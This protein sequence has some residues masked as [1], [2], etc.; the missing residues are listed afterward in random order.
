LLQDLF[1]KVANIINKGEFASTHAVQRV[2]KK[3]R[4]LLANSDPERRNQA[5]QML[6]ALSPRYLLYVP[7]Q[8][9]DRHLALY[10]KL[11][12]QPFAWQIDAPRSNERR[13]VTLCAPDQPGLF[14]KIAGVLTLHRINILDAQI[15][16]WR[17]RTALDIFEVNP[18]PDRIYE[19]EKWAQ[20]AKD[21]EAALDGELDLHARLAKRATSAPPGPLPGAQRNQRVRIDNESSSFWTIVE[22]FANDY[23]GL[24]FQVTNALYLCG[25]DIRVAKITTKLDQV[26]DVFYV[27]DLDGQKIEDP[28]RL[29]QIKKA[30]GAKLARK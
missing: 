8:E 14:S 15:Y 12:D 2:E 3:K 21:L 1:L 6:T 20:A 23:T 30:V 29:A 28:G 9:I 10:S 16:T 22:V 26:L 17:N 11:V 25:V 18:P 24:L 27:S 4:Q 19:K 5:E 13:T 7:A